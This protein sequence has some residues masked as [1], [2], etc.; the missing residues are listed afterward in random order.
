MFKKQSILGLLTILLLII[1]ANATY[2]E[3]CTWDCHPGFFS[4]LGFAD[5]KCEEL[6]YPVATY[7]YF[8]EPYYSGPYNREYKVP[9]YGTKSLTAETSKDLSHAPHAQRK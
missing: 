3:E 9:L 8:H 5:Y 1:G 2:D 7:G 4:L 6:C